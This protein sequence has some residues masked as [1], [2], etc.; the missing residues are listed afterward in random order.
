M[1]LT[2]DDYSRATQYERRETTQQRGEKVQD[3]PDVGAFTVKPNTK[4]KLHDLNR[5]HPDH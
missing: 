5:K 2:D 4:P 3:G 1:F